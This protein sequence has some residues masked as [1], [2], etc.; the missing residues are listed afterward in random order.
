[1]EDQTVS[2]AILV[3]CSKWRGWGGGGGVASS[4]ASTRQVSPVWMWVRPGL[5]FKRDLQTAKMFW[6]YSII[7]SNYI[8][9]AAPNAVYFHSED[10]CRRLLW[11]RTWDHIVNVLNIHTFRWRSCLSAEKHC[12]W[13]NNGSVNYSCDNIHGSLKPI[14]RRR[15]W[16]QY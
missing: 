3:H 13:E 15:I 12:E 6:V 2:E 16:K 1:M 14:Y 11:R 4:P 10:S 9:N 5:T 8:L 7:H